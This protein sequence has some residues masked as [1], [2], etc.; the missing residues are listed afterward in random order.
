MK[1]TKNFEWHFNQDYT[2]EYNQIVLKELAESEDNGQDYIHTICGFGGTLYDL[3][4]EE[5]EYIKNQNPKKIWS[6][7]EDLYDS[8]G[9]YIGDSDNDSF[10]VLN[11]FY[12]S[13]NVYGYLVTEEECK[14]DEICYSS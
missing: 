12:D 6:V 5:L 7:F 9:N 14:E 2:C 4:A 1:T 3:G 8:E 10:Y 11:G 13:P